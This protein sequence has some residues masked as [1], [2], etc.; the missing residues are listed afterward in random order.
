MGIICIIQIIQTER[1]MTYL[2]ETT[3]RADLEIAAIF[4]CNIDCAIVETATDEE[5]LSMVRTWIEAGDECAA[6]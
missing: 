6:A 1:E 3:S 5:L 2:D 4:E